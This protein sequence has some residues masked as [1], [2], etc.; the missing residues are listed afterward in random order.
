MRKFHHHK[1]MNIVIGAIVYTQLVL[2][3]SGSI[4]LIIGLIQN[5]APT[6]FG[7]YG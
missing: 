7:I 4:S 3:I 2:I 1:V 6:S 5:G